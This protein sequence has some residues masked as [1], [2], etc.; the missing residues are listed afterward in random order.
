[1]E[2]ITNDWWPKSS[3]GEYRRRYDVLRQAM[4]EKGLDCLAV[5]GAPLFFGTDP[6]AAFIA[7]TSF[8][9]D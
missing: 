6:G 7:S 2:R 9:Q 8:R 4:A 3:Q 1:M 5:Y